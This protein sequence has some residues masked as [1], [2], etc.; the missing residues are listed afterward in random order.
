MDGDTR[1]DGDKAEDIIALDRVAA[2]TKFILY[3]INLLVDNQ[4]IAT[5]WCLLATLLA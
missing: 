5:L 3:V 4:R 1:I 2:A